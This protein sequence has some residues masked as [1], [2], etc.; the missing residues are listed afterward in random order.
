MGCDIHFHLERY[1]EKTAKWQEIPGPVRKCWSCEGA[2]HHIARGGEKQGEDIK[3]YWCK[4]TGKKRE[5][6]YEGRNYNLFA[7]LADVRNGRGF[8]GI[9][10]GE[11]FTPIA[12]PKG[13]PP[14]VSGKIQKASDEYGCDG[15]S[16]SWHTLQQ[17]LDYDWEGQT[18]T[19]QGVI[20]IGDYA[21]WKLLCADTGKQV[22]PR[23]YSGGIFGQNIVTTEPFL[24]DSLLKSGDVKVLWDEP[25]T[26]PLD[27]FR[28]D[29]KDGNQYYVRVSWDETY[30]EAAGEYFFTEV[31]EPL[32]AF[33]KKYG[34]NDKLRIVF[35]FDN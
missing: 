6:W 12:G 22:A 31:I 20:S 17:L 34:G 4:G 2:G 35:W 32:K 13:L 19:L 10:T 29:S 7:M 5:E 25:P 24:A 1:N 30:R 26:G 11:G 16:H 9:K 27:H 18:T 3:C 15:H 23:S 21:H 28:S 8:A 33:A 14:D